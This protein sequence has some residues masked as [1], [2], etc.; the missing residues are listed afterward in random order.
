MTTR[1]ADEGAVLVGLLR[2]REHCTF[3][4]QE[5]QGGGRR[6]VEIYSTHC[7]ACVGELR[8]LGY[9]VVSVDAGAE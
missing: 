3:S 8:R 2:L 9:V 4:W 5:P 7:A 6:T 1:D